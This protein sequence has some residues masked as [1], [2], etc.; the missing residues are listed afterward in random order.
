M[1]KVL[2]PAFGLGG[3]FDRA[4]SEYPDAS[5]AVGTDEYW[6]EQALLI[7]MNSVGLSPPNPSVGCV[8]VKDQKVLAS[9][10][11]QACGKEHAERMAFE[12]LGKNPDLSE[13]T[14]YVTL[15]P[16]SHFGSQ[17]PCVDLFL[18]HPVKRIV[19]AL[20]DPDDRVNG[21]GIKKLQAIGTEVKL[22]VLAEEARAFQF[23][24]LANRILKR[25]VW[26]AKWAQ[27]PDGCL[28]D[29]EDQSKWITGPKSR[30][31]THWLRQKYDLI[32]VG[33]RTFLSDKPALTV[34]D[35]APPHHR[36]PMRVVFDPKGLLLDRLE[37]LD[38][39]NV[40]VMESVLKGLQNG[41]APSCWSIPEGEARLGIRFQ[42]AVEAIPRILPLQ[43]IMVEGGASLL[44]E[45][46]ES[47]VFDAAHIFTGTRIFDKN[48]VKHRVRW[49]PDSQWHRILQH[50][51]DQDHLQEW[52]K[53]F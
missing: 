44:N 49:R 50:K 51:F 32:V 53:E 46:L 48:S 16:C 34:R 43:S 24:F 39:W 17:P 35:S 37:E 47:E 3:R 30:A 14:A 38:G 2:S 15:E 28:A 18:K 42:K 52:V 23:P 29:S 21:E 7:S 11:T 45:L 5:F 13:V 40:F 8:L 4:L 10:F 6:M 9:G 36:N 26:I 31:Y 19:I 20:M 25:P 33:A 27:T 1:R 12:N 22:G 41:P